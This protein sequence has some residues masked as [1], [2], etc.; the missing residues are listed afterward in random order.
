MVEDATFVQLTEDRMSAASAFGQL[1][2]PHESIESDG[3]P[4]IPVDADHGVG[5]SLRGYLHLTRNRATSSALRVT[6]RQIDGRLG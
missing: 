5:S 1:D 6:V 2:D 4:W 3:T